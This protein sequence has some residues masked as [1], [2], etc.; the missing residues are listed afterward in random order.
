MK[1]ISRIK[2]IATNVRCWAEQ[3]QK[4]DPKSYNKKLNCLCAISSYELFKRLKRAKINATVNFC[5]LGHAFVIVDDNIL[6]DVTATQF[7]NYWDDNPK[8][9][10][11]EIRELEDARDYSEWWSCDV[12]CST[13]E[14][15]AK[16]M[17]GWPS[18]QKH[19]DIQKITGK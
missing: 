4:E 7:N 8:F 11:I 2:R 10:K 3:R 1:K 18:S 19:K 14:E 13:K 6:V 17:Y 5:N 9:N 12:T 15:I 16:E